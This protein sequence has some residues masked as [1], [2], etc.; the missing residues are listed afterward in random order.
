MDLLIASIILFLA[1]LAVLAIYSDKSRATADAEQ[2]L[3]A[4]RVAELVAWNANTLIQCVN[5]TKTTIFLPAVLATGENYS[6]A[7]V[8]RRVQVAWKNQSEARPLL[9]SSVSGAAALAPGRNV[10]ITNDNGGILFG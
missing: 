8:G 9:T 7:V 1:F 4:S 6:I 2:R 5:G 3:S 10:S